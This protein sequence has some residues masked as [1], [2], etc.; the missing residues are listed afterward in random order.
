MSRIDKYLWSVR[1]FKTRGIAA[2]MVKTNKVH[3]NNNTVK[4]SKNVKIGD[5]LSIRIKTAVFTYKV[6]D[7]P[8]SRIGAKLVK[9]YLLDITPKEELDKYEVYQLA[10]KSYKQNEFGKPSKKDIRALNKFLKK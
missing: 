10:Q 2:E 8:K 5:I 4:S 6:I 9:D 7:I 3:I 1:L